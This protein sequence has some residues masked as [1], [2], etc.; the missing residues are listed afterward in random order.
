M[1]YNLDL[2]KRALPL[3][4]ELPRDEPCETVNPG[5]AEIFRE[6]FLIQ[7]PLPDSYSEA[8]VVQWIDKEIMP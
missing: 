5:L 6:V 1:I 2:A 8:C 3:I 4:P 7:E